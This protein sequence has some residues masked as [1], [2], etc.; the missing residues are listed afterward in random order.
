[1]DRYNKQQKHK[2]TNI[3]LSEPLANKIIVYLLI[4]IH[5]YTHILTVFV[6]FPHL[7]FRALISAVFHSTLV[8]DSILLH[9]HL[10]SLLFLLIDICTHSYLLVI[11]YSPSLLLMFLRGRTAPTLDHVTRDR[12]LEPLHRSKETCEEGTVITIERS[13]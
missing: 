13:R 4:L 10:T 1:M 2:Y 8:F 6:L 9:L 12:L 5:T 11:T 7:Y 3:Q